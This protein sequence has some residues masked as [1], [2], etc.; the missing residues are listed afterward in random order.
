MTWVEWHYTEAKE[1]NDVTSLLSIVAD[2]LDQTCFVWDVAIVR[3]D[4]ILFIEGG[5]NPYQMDSSIRR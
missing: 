4:A 2:H 3:G 1:C 5:M